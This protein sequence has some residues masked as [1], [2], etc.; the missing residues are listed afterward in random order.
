MTQKHSKT[1]TCTKSTKSQANSAHHPDSHSNDGISKSGISSEELLQHMITA[2]ARVRQ[3]EAEEIEELIRQGD[4]DLIIDSKE[5][6]TVIA[7][8]IGK[9]G[10][11][12]PGPSDLKSDQLSSIRALLSLVK[13]KL[14][15][16]GGSKGKN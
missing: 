9:I 6:E 13:N 3:V 7:I 10:C 14:L 1:T 16:Q 5:G 2:L 8:L 11:D 15:P 12:L 4:G